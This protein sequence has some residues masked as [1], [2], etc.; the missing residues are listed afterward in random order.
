[1]T[2]GTAFIL[3]FMV[4]GL[5]FLCGLGA[6]QLDRLQWKEGLIARVQKNLQ[7]EPEPVAAV[8]ADAERTRDGINYIPV[9]LSGEYLALKPIFEFTTFKGASGWNVYALLE[10][11]EQDRFADS[12]YAVINRGFIPYNERQAFENSVPD[13]AKI[14]VVGLLR[15]PPEQQ[16]SAAFDNEL[17]N[18]T[19]YWRDIEAMATVFKEDPKIVAPWYIDLGL[20]KSG[21]GNGE[22][23]IAGTTLINFPNNH[24]QYAFTWFGLAG[25]LLLVGGSFLW[26]RRK[27][28]AA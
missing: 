5:V 12:Q 13:S 18:R 16:P 22:F 1:M 25:T 24:L 28:N 27:K 6:W 26:S 11:V 21:A 14:E 7:G 10:I 8:L 19:F 9:K 20:P 15:S 23:P 17:D 2:R 3:A 4:A